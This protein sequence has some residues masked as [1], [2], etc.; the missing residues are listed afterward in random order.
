MTIQEAIAWQETFKK[1]YAGFP[2]EADI[3]CDMAIE[4]LKMWE[5]EAK[6]E[7]PDTTKGI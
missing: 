3:A 4:A 2:K 6:K 7:K 1:T 5:Q